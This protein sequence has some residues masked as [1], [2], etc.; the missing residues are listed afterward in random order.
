[1]MLFPEIHRR[2]GCLLSQLCFLLVA[3]ICFG[4][5]HPILAAAETITPYMTVE[6]ALKHSPQLQALNHSQQAAQFDLKQSRGRYLPSVDLSLGYGSEQHSDS[7]TRRAGSD[8]N[9]SDWS[10]RGDA[11]LRLTQKI[12]DGGETSQQVEIQQALLDS[13]NFQIKSAAQG[14]ALGA[15]TA[16]LDVFKQRELV[17]LAK[18]NLHA[19]QDIHQSLAEREQAGA[20]NIAD[21]TQ[22]QARMARAQSTLYLS[23]ADLSKSLANYTRMVGVSPRSENITYAG[24]PETLPKTLEKALE[25]MVQ[26]NPEL[27]VMAAALVEADARVALAR[28]PYKPKIDIQLSS[29]YNDQLEGDRSWQNTNDAMLNLSWNLFNGGQDKAG[30]AA[31]LARKYQSRSTRDDKLFELQEATAAAWATYKSLHGQKVAYR[32]AVDYSQKTFDAYLHQFS[33]SQRSLLDVLSAENEYFQSASQLVSV[34]VNETLAAYQILALT[35][36]LQVPRCSGG[37]EYPEDLQ[38][39]KQ[40]LEVPSVTPSVSTAAQKEPLPEQSIQELINRSTIAWEGQ[41]VEAYLACYSQQF[42]PESDNSYQDWQRLRSRKLTTPLFIDLAISDLQIKRQSNTVYRVNFM[43]R[44][45]SDRYNDKLNKKLLLKCQNETWKIISEQVAPNTTVILPSITSTEQNADMR[46]S[47]QDG[48]GHDLTGRE[49]LP[50]Y[51]VK[52]G[53]CINAQEVDSVREILHTLKLNFNQSTGIGKVKVI[54]LLGGIYP[55]AEA[56]D[57]LSKI[58]KQVNDAYLLPEKNHQLGLYL[59]SFHN[60]ERATRFADKLSQRGIKAQ[61]V[62]AEVS[63]NGDIFLSQETDTKTAQLL[64]SSLAKSGLSTNLI[65]SD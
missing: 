34:T 23:N 61:L 21:V 20:G 31:A 33:V 32:D 2:S 49:L 15:I 51:T 58:K 36:N 12:Y 16:H 55:A 27:Q 38:W 45:Q 26:G 63:M 14:V 62:A 56:H 40:A 7:A 48:A 4:F 6:Q 42:T 59:G 5:L 47:S 60:A 10:S 17:D 13:A 37:R 18:K 41:D 52:I 50:A 43:Q 1:M 35:G 46:E 22:A 57:K 11:A 19:H 3:T 53:P 65:M 24:V 54:R 9:D 44:Y 39:L 64:M 30:A 8:P 25:L 28:S 29:R